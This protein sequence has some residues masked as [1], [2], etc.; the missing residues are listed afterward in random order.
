MSTFNLKLLFL[1]G[2][3]GKGVSPCGPTAYVGIQRYLHPNL[4][5]SS[6]KNEKVISADCVSFEEFQPEV[7][8]L[9]KELNVIKKQAEQR[10]AEDSARET[11]DLES[12]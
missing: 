12:H 6:M 11:R 9:I 7:D 3:Y 10:F 1:P 4:R 5:D 2:S 8:R